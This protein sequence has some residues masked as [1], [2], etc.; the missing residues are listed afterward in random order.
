MT[1]A[2]YLA[3]FTPYTNE[4]I[5]ENIKSMPVKTCKSDAI[6][7]QALK[8]VLPLIITPLTSLINLSL[9]EGVLLSPGKWLL[10]A[11]SLKS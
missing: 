3:E 1:T 7:T 9:Q 10:S 6:P 2:S 5:E 4:E 8:G 11:P